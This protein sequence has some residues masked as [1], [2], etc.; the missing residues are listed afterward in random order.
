M[1]FWGEGT[2]EPRVVGDYTHE[3]DAFADKFA[4]DARKDR[5]KAYY[6]AEFCRRRGKNSEFAA[7]VPIRYPGDQLLP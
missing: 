2:S 4:K 3:V 6:N 1:L 7:H 5:L